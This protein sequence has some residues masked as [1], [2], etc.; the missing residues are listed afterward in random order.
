[1]H[2][3]SF[4]KSDSLSERAKQD[5]FVSYTCQCIDYI[6]NNVL[7]NRRHFKEMQII[8]DTIFLLWQTT[9][10]PLYGTISDEL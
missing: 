1:M 3:L 2:T 9:E 10:H 7:F 5:G 4:L 8:Q 6:R